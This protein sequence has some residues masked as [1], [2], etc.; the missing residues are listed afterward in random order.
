M[1]KTRAYGADAQLTGVAEATYGTAP[2]GAAGGVYAL[3]PFKSISL[4]AEKPLGYDPLLGQGRDAQDPYYDAESVAGDVEVPLDLRDFGFWLKGLFGAPVTTDNM[5]GT[6]DHVF[7]SGGDLPSLALEIGHTALTVA[8][9]LLYSG[10]KAGGLSF[11]MARSGPANAT[12]D[13]IAQGEASAATPEDASPT[14]R[15]LTRFNNSKGAITVGGTQL[16]NVTGGQFNFSNNLE[17]VETIRA[18]GL[19]DGVD[20]TEATVEGSVTVRM[21][22]DTT[23]T[24]PIAA[25]TPVAMVFSFTRPGAEGY[26]LDFSMP[27][28][29]LPKKKGEIS[30]PGGIEQ[31]YDFRA[32]F[33]STAGHLLQVT[34]VNDVAAY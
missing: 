1:A 16:G 33:D 12:I 28:V 29:F 23:L 4:G 34:L 3:L 31:T 25:E 21:G 13:L 9:Y 2:D 17:A 8:R 7:T 5:D 20:E 6:Y 10:L 24:T 32:A 19:I 15:S 26:R 22:T 18:D 30:G 11:D 14:T 27:R